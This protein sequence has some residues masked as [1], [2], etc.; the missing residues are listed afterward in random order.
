MYDLPHPC[1]LDYNQKARLKPLKQDFNDGNRICK[2]DFID[3]EH[4]SRFRSY[5]LI[6][7][8]FR[9]SSDVDFVTIFE[10]MP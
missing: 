4:L 2:L 3:L 8:I 1:Y 9:Y 7:I 10:V 5:I 6:V